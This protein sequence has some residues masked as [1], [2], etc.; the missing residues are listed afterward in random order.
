MIT[1]T[2]KLMKQFGI[3]T[4]CSCNTALFTG[5]S[6]IRIAVMGYEDRKPTSS[7]LDKMKSLLKEAMEEGSRGMTTG[8]IYPPGVFSDTDELVELCKVMAPYDGIYAT[9]LRNESYDFVNAVKEAIEIGKRA[10]VRVQLSHHKAYGKKNWG[11]TK[12]TLR[13]VSEANA[14]GQRIS[15]DQYPYEASM[16]HF[17]VL[18]PPKYFNG[19]INNLIKSLKDR[20]TRE[21]IRGEIL[22]ENSAFDNY[23]QNCGGFEGVFASA[24]PATPQYDGMFVSDIATMLKKDPFDTYFDLVIDNNGSGSGIYF[25][26]GEEDICRVIMDPNVMVGSD[27]ICK[28]M[29]EKGHPRAWGTFPHAICYFNKQK[30]L[31]SLEEIIRK[32]TSL[33]AERLMLKG[34]GTIADGMD[35]D[36]VVFNYEELQD[37]ASY[38]CSNLT[39]KGI[40]YV[41]VN[42]EVVYEDMHLTGKYPGR[43]LAH[44]TNV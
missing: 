36:L 23:Y 13:L 16:T 22:D 39:T 25:S 19:G 30:H 34:K 14:E 4:R 2:A 10:G 33:P 31:M 42:G 11:L 6:A 43:F 26:I 38:K 17:N 44:T 5:H 15:I 40:K 3:G 9:H 21:T 24:L 20:R 1:Q 7:E 41:V 18:I 27:G 32:M 37:M 28:A 8:L 29:D 35:A 12:E